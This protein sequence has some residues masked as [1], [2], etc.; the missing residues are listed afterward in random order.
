MEKKE[1]KK[2]N[3]VLVTVLVVLLLLVFTGFGYAIG[4]VRLNKQTMKKVSTTVEEKEQ[5]NKTTMTVYET[6]D[7]KITSLLD[8]LFSFPTCNV[9]DMYAKD[10]VVTNKDITNLQAYNMVQKNYWNQESVSLEEFQKAIHK[11]LG[12]DYTFDP[13]SINYQGETCP[14]FNYDASSQTFKKQETACG[15]TC[16]PVGTH[17]QITKAVEENGV[18]T[19]SL[20]VVFGD[21]GSTFYAD[22]KH[23]TVLVN[24]VNEYTT[25]PYAKGNLYKVVYKL[26]DG[27]YVFN[28]IGLA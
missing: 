4:G 6:T 10:T 26:E 19:L 20:R 13:T 25:V 1:E 15:W 22:S 3:G 17:Y 16:G 14:Q 27:N 24:D 9:V 11:Y 12:K 28:S 18:L 8:T 21:G 7:E 23:N 2:T 5:N